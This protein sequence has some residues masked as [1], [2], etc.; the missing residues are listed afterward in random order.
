VIYGMGR[1]SEGK[2]L[3]L[4]RDVARDLQKGFAPPNVDKSAPKGIKSQPGRKRI[5]LKR[6]ALKAEMISFR[7]RGKVDN[8]TISSSGHMETFFL[9]ADWF[10]KAQDPRGGWGVPVQR[11]MS[12]GALKLEP[13]W[14]SAMAQGQA[15]SVLARAYHASDSES[16][17]SRY[18]EAASAALDL[19]NVP[20]SSGGVRAEFMGKHPWYE[21]YPTT[22]SSFVLN[23]FMYA[24]MG[25]YDAA[26]ILPQP[27]AS[28]AA[29]LYADGMKSLKA[30]LPLFDTG[31]GSVYDLRHL[32]LAGSGVPPN[33]ARWDYHTTHINQLLLL[34]SV[35]N[36]SEVLTSV[37]KRWIGYMTGKRAPHN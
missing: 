17:R 33:L 21:E 12:N 16:K 14:Y 29:R 32:T 2:W 3:R 24:L 35:D 30:L 7:G 10:V 20:S 4:V 11:R 27:A 28:R 6:S 15:L 26:E 9:A 8:V 34:A 18:S 13:G 23:G 22:P 25:L 31:S 19:F 37:A 1:E 5:K 36:E